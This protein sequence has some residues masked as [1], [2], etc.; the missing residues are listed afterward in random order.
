MVLLLKSLRARSNKYACRGGSKSQGIPSTI[1]ANRRVIARKA[2]GRNR[3]TIYYGNQVGGIG[4]RM[5]SKTK[6]TCTHPIYNNNPYNV[7]DT[8]VR[9]ITFANNTT[10][11]DALKIYFGEIAGPSGFTPAEIIQIGSFTNPSTKGNISYWDVSNVTIMLNAFN[12]A[13]FNLRQNFNEN[14]GCWNVS[15]VYDMDFMFQGQALFNVD[16]GK[17]DVGKAVSMFFMFNN[18]FSFSNSSTRQWKINSIPLVGGMF[19]DTP[20]AISYSGYM[21]VGAVYGGTPLFTYFYQ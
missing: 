5:R 8:I 20:I 18:C 17:W 19:K 2:V 6:C 15:N 13:V 1:G 10:F 7:C 4:I 3:G 16:I 14:I 21:R 11:Q 12:V 9:T